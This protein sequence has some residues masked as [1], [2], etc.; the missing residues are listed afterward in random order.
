MN[1]E[2]DVRGLSCP[3]PVL[4]TKQAV[5]KGATS[6]IV[7][8]D[9]AVSRENVQKFLRSAGFEVTV[10]NNNEGGWEMRATKPAA[11]K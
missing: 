7:Q 11:G 2:L 1:V 3:I 6:L 4:K 5:D 9:S 8:G 10:T